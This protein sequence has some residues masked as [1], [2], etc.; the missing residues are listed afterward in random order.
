L[1]RLSMTDA[2]MGTR[3]ELIRT[4]SLGSTSSVAIFLVVVGEAEDPGR[5]GSAIG[6][7]GF[8][9]FADPCRRPD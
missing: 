1:P 4:T 3:F 2:G 7:V 5:V 6:P 8:V 9:G